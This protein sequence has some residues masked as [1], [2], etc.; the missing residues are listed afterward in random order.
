MST[1]VGHSGRAMKLNEKATEVEVGEPVAGTVEGAASPAGTSIG[2][3][4][5]QGEMPLEPRGAP[6]GHRRRV[7]RTR[8]SAVA[9]WWFAR[10]RETVRGTREWDG[11]AARSE[12]V[13][14]GTLA[15]VQPP[16]R[17]EGYRA[18]DGSGSRTVQS[19]FVRDM[20]PR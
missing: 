10:M 14:Q 19:A 16:T 1:R 3:G 4:S 7:V 13:E 9:R 17:F 20:E 2:A 15:L 6:A 18:S 5:W 11:G 12:G 8:R